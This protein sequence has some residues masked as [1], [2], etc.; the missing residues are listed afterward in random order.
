MNEQIETS[1]NNILDGR[2]LCSVEQAARA[3]C[4]STRTVNA[5][6]AAKILGS[7]KIGRRRLIVV[8]SLRAFASKDQKGLSP[9]SGA[10]VLK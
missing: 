2:L 5:Y 6:L 10:T 9:W 1:D 8:T 4:L 7:R 3:L